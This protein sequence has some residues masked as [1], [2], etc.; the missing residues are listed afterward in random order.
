MAPGSLSTIFDDRDPPLSKTVGLMADMEQMGQGPFG[1]CFALVTGVQERPPLTC[2]LVVLVRTAAQ[3]FGN[4]GQEY[5]QK[6]GAKWEHIAE[7]AAKSHTHSKNNPYAQF[8]E[9]R[10]GKDVLSDK[11]VTQYMT[12]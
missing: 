2:K 7:I 6:F 1:S 4:G 9:P 11:K 10:S 8:H 5:C 3:I 12:R